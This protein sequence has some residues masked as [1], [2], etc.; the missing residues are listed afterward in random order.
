L[1]GVQDPGAGRGELGDPGGPQCAVVAVV[2]Q[3]LRDV[4][5]LAGFLLPGD[6]EQ[7]HRGQAGVGA[8]I[9]LGQ[10]RHLI[11]GQVVAGQHRRGQLG[12]GHGGG[13]LHPLGRGVS[14]PGDLP[15][16]QPEIEELL[17]GPDL[18]HR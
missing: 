17:M 10:D 11:Q 3:P 13:D 2:A 4:R 18:L 1:S 12:A 7:L 5:E 14:A 16:R 9:E 6:G 15:G 8:V